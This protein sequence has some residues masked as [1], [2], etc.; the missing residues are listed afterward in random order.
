MEGS[1][2]PRK[3]DAVGTILR[4]QEGVDFTVHETDMGVYYRTNDGTLISWNELQTYGQYA[5]AG[6]EV[7]PAGFSTVRAPHAIRRD[8]ALAA[9]SLRS[10][11]SDYEK[12][13]GEVETRIAEL[14]GRSNL[15]EAER[16][17]L[18]SL[19][20]S[21]PDL[22]DQLDFW[23]SALIFNSGIAKGLKVFDPGMPGTPV[24]AR[25]ENLTDAQRE[26]LQRNLRLGKIVLAFSQ[27]ENG[28][29]TQ[30][31]FDD[32]TQ[33]VRMES[34]MTGTVFEAANGS[35]LPSSSWITSGYDPNRPH[36]TKVNEILAHLAIDLESVQLSPGKKGGLGVVTVEDGVVLFAGELSGYGNTV[37][38]D[39]G[40]GITTL[41]A[42]NRSL[43]VSQGDIVM[44]GQ[45]LSLSGNTSGGTGMS[46][47][48]H[49]HF[50]VMNRG[51]KVNPL[52]FDWRPPR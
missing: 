1:L 46:L 51:S 31:V 4:G 50:E 11:L 12:A 2:D 24:D 40:N 7:I 18:D 25:M 32:K 27:T 9:E 41:Y 38:V 20:S 13:V 47:G 16:L 10:G 6:A 28:N 37:I 48:E 43:N 42:H 52:F 15:T 14:Q 33:T 44:K 45:V 22:R 29:V 26:Y 8:A 5:G 49:I 17:E 21:Y 23:K 30:L 39:H 19:R 3:L 35:R 36:P 34:Y